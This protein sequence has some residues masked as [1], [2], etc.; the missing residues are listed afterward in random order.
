MREVGFHL[1]KIPYPC[2]CEAEPLDLHTVLENLVPFS[3][4]K[5]TNC[6]VFCTELCSIQVKP[7]GFWGWGFAG[8][9]KAALITWFIH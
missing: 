5:Q 4:K 7:E 9:I 6:G 8:G 3:T 2:M 1:S